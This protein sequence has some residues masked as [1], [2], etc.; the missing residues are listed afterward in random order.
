M[1]RPAGP[2]G[3]RAAEPQHADPPRRGPGRAEPVPRAEAGVAAVQPQG[4][5]H[6][7][8]P[9]AGA[10]G[11]EHGAGAA[12]GEQRVDGGGERGD[13]ERPEQ[14]AEPPG[15][16]GGRD[17]QAGE[18][19]ERRHRVAGPGGVRGEP[20][21]GHAVQAARDDAAA[22]EIEDSLGLVV[23]H[24][25]H[26]TRA[27]A[28]PRTTLLVLDAFPTVKLTADLSHWVIAAER[29]F[30][31][32]SDAA[33][34]PPILERVANATVLTHARV[35]SAEAI[36][37]NDPSAPEHAA[38]V[39]AGDDRGGAQSK[40]GR[41]HGAFFKN[42]IA[43]M[44]LDGDGVIS[45]VEFLYAFEGWVGIDEGSGGEDDE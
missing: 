27:L 33:Y 20:D 16:H 5:H 12:G 11:A 44:E 41:V 26:R 40:S 6:D 43:E 25:T 19:G 45:F 1:A 28:T 38:L 21:G 17:H 7:P 34:W 13:E 15:A 31:Y 39:E 4:L 35:G 23:A 32:P 36:Q 2:A 9:A 8:H 24:E 22:V 10:P 42:R 18:G 3:R 37:V 29:A 14:R 30:D